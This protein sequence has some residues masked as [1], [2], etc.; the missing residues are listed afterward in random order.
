MEIVERLI[1]E[2]VERLIVEIVEELIVERLMVEELRLLG[3]TPQHSQLLN[4]LNNQHSQQP[5]PF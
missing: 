1:V 3:E 4:N 2:I 5:Q